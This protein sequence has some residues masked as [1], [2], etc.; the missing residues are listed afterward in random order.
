MDADGHSY[1]DVGT[2]SQCTHLGLDLL[3]LDRRK[4]EILHG[5]DERRHQVPEPQ[6]PTAESSRDVRHCLELMAVMPRDDHVDRERD[7]LD[8]A[9]AH[10]LQSPGVGAFSAEP[11]VAGL[12]GPVEAEGDDVQVAEVRQES[13]VDVREVPTVGDEAEPV[14]RL[15]RPA[16]DF[17]ELRVDRRVVSG[18]AEVIEAIVSSLV[19]DSVE[20]TQR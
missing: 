20:H 14:A 18:E 2:L 13:R 8:D 10:R 4:I 6:P 12:G 11:V 9:D 15:G 7:L 5:G 19:E 16:K 1:R 17:R 3:A